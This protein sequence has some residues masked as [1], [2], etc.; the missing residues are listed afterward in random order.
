MSAG[1]GPVNVQLIAVVE[2][3]LGCRTC[4]TQPCIEE[5]KHYFQKGFFS[6]AGAR[7]LFVFASTPESSE[8]FSSSKRDEGALGS[9]WQ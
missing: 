9:S 4:P 5:N 8:V 3:A 6:P 1:S 7:A 2:Q